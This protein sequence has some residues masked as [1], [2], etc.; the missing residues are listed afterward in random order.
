MSQLFGKEHPSLLAQQQLGH[1]ALHMGM[2][3]PP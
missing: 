3:C 1:S 2:R